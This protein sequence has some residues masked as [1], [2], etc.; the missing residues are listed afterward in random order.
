ML[1][2]SGMIFLKYV[3][4]IFTALDNAVLELKTVRQEEEKKVSLHIYSSSMLLPELIQRIQ[5]ADPD[6]RVS[7]FQ[8]PLEEN[9]HDS[10]LFLTSSDFLPE[11]SHIIPLIKE[12]LVAALP[13]NHPLAEKPE[14][15]LDDLKGESFLSLNPASN[16]ASTLHHYCNQYQFEPHITNYADNP[17]MIRD[18]LRLNLGIAFIPEYTWW[19]FASAQILRLPPASQRTEA[20]SRHLRS[21]VFLPVSF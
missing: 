21:P 9:R 12:P 3:D 5:K 11:E 8:Q 1:N 7:I 19:G 6:I 17:A 14:L 13:K 20:F 15:F 4:E 16:L 18:L 10:S 2:Q